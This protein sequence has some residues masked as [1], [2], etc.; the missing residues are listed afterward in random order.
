MV[1]TNVGD[2][3]TGKSHK[4]ENVKNITGKFYIAQYPDL[5]T[6][7]STLHFT[8]VTDMF[9]QTPSWLLWEVASHIQ[10]L[11]HEGCSYTYPVI[12][13]KDRQIE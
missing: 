11:M 1:L 13:V 3:V 2:K 8:S 4:E 9:T 12:N 7:Q 5:G 6:V 10:Q